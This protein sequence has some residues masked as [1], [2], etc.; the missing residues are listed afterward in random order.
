[1]RGDS[2][3]DVVQVGVSEGDL[4][5]EVLDVV[6]SGSGIEEIVRKRSG[7]AFASCGDNV[8]G[9]YKKSNPHHAER[10]PLGD[11]AAAFMGFPKAGGKSV[12]Y[13]ELLLESGVSVDEK[14]REAGGG[15]KP[16]EKRPVNLVETLPYIR[17]GA[18]VRSIVQSVALHL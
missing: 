12:V 6:G 8:P 7:T 14:R 4:F 2:G 16:V 18:A 3:S 1:M 15:G 13:E 17:S 10:A 5:D 9:V 11:S